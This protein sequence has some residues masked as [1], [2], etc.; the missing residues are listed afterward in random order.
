[1]FLTFVNT[2]FL[3]LSKSFTEALLLCLASSCFPTESTSFKL[4]V[5]PTPAVCC[6][7]TPLALVQLLCA[8]LA[9]YI[10]PC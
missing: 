4:I 8:V 2:A 7:A 1:M 3:R 5:T 10:Y 9:V 6:S